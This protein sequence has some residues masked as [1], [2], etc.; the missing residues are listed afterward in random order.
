MSNK[1][2][3]IGKSTLSLILCLTMLLTT[4]CFFD[5]GSVISKAIVSTSTNRIAEAGS[6]NFF[7]TYS[8]EAPELVYMKA[9]GNRSEYFLMS[10]CDANGNALST[11]EATGDLSFTCATASSIA[12]VGT[13]KTAN[14][15]DVKDGNYISGV[16]TSNG[17]TNS[18]VSASK[19]VT[20]NT[21]GSI[22]SF[23]TA[24]TSINLGKVAPGTEY[25]IEWKITYRC[26]S[27]DC[28]TYAYTGVKCPYLGQA[29][30]ASYS[31]YKSSGSRPYQ[32]AYS[33]IT[34][35]DSVSGGNAKSNFTNYYTSGTYS[36]NNL[37]APLSK[38]NGSS[39]KENN[40]YSMPNIA[41]GDKKY[42]NMYSVVDGAGYDGRYFTQQYGGGVF[43]TVVND[44]EHSY[45]WKVKGYDPYDPTGYNPR[46]YNGKNFD[47]S[48]SGWAYNNGGGYGTGNLT[49]D[50]SR[51][52]DFKDIPNLSSGW[53]QLRYHYY[54]VGNYLANIDNCV[55]Y[56]NDPYDN[57]KPANTH[58]AKNS[59]K[60]SWS[61]AT[62]YS[63]VDTR[64]IEDDENDSYTRGL[65]PLNG[66]ISSVMNDKVN[67]HNSGNK[68]TTYFRFEFT[69]SYDSITL[70]RKNS[71]VQTVGFSFNVAN[72]A[73]IRKQYVEYLN[74]GANDK[75]GSWSS[76]NT[77]VRAMVKRLCVS[78]NTDTT[79]INLSSKISN[80]QNEL[81]KTMVGEAL[82]PVAFVV[83][84]AIYL[85][86]SGT[87]FKESTTSLFQ[88]FIQN[89][90]DTSSVT[91]LAENAKKITQNESPAKTGNIYFGYDKVKGNVSISFDWVLQSDIN[92]LITTTKTSGTYL[93]GS[94][95][96]IKIGSQVT[97]ASSNTSGTKTVSISPDSKGIALAT[98]DRDNS[99]SPYF[100]ASTTGAYI[101]WTAKYTDKVDNYE[102]MVI[103]YTYVYKPY[104][105]P[106]LAGASAGTGAGGANWTEQGTWMTGFHSVTAASNGNTL[107][108]KY[109]NGSNSF[110]AFIGDEARVMAGTKKI[111]TSP[112]N[113]REWK[114]S[115]D[116]ATR[117]P[118]LF[119]DMNS[120]YNNYGYFCIGNYNTNTGTYVT[121]VASEGFGIAT[122]NH[123][124]KK[125]NDTLRCQV[126]VSAAK[127]KIF[128]DKSRYTNLQYIPNLNVGHVIT[129]DQKSSSNSGTWYIA[130]GTGRTYS[131]G[132][133]SGSKGS[134]GDV[135]KAKSYWENKNHII[136]GQSVG[137]S[138]N[139]YNE[140]EGVRYAGKWPCSINTSVESQTYQ[141]VGF[142][143]NNDGGYRPLAFSVVTLDGILTDKSSLRDSVNYAQKN[144]ATLGVFN[145][146]FES[147]YFSGANWNSLVK[148]YKD[149]CAVLEKVDG[150]YSSSYDTQAEINSLAT[151]LRKAVENYVNGTVKGDTLSAQQGS[152]GFIQH[153]G[154]DG[155]AQITSTIPL[156][157]I[158]STI[159]KGTYARDNVSFDLDSITGYTFNGIIRSNSAIADIKSGDC[160]PGISTLS[161]NYMTSSKLGK[162][163]VTW[164]ANS[165]IKDAGGTL[166][167]NGTNGRAVVNSAGSKVDFSYNTRQ[168]GNMN[169][170][171][172]YSADH[173]TVA[174]NLDNGTG[175]SSSQTA[176]YDYTLKLHTAP[177]KKG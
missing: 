102:K 19:S 174:Y 150:Y 54:G 39:N 93:S 121:G 90:V 78:T 20:I 37:I 29:G 1:L 25:I 115:S 35:L 140:T 109:V 57:W 94:Y 135:S 44:D 73:E 153:Y 162:K 106:V 157:K 95:G 161:S 5:I 92:S 127:P 111:T 9:G 158:A 18:I 43:S 64:S 133:W 108:Y 41:E 97:S 72:K 169:L 125:S 14:L 149:A 50:T 6:S 59:G 167:Q 83:P 75:A 172:I 84:E 8:I 101:R 89:N 28:N 40:S 71:M 63:T 30:M 168:D 86:P 48:S 163:T 131:N 142:S 56:D 23:R 154:A 96:S 147:Y 69:N 156:K 119:Q 139:N 148:Y 99:W 87:S 124:S 126:V 171:Y 128:I 24:I 141:V 104:M 45:I 176:T 55:Y 173:F 103:A 70:T 175:T 112:T 152:V 116:G 143:S 110:S 61:A 12:I 53:V 31:R 65:Y 160:I 120:T 164:N 118:I 76:L 15:E 58:T 60:T 166:I 13:L 68:Y 165:T 155:S 113:T 21:T 74:S 105:V 11:T 91:N 170:Y 4:F 7:S 129:G 67:T 49:I 79:A 46:S 122:E 10:D 88:Y 32:Y 136:A 144:M 47:D 51:F 98:I 17:L 16:T 100:S 81:K 36:P 159:V 145:S 123:D 151:N 107:R 62:I 34:G 114:Q 52:S 38:F 2:T 130:D 137:Y 146:S 138:D 134:N 27:T 66:N 42:L 177:T 3:K 22:S 26:G 33:F 85:T 80:I 132:T 77:D 82:S 117:S